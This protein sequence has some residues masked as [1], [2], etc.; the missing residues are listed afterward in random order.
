MKISTHLNIDMVAL[1]H[2]DQVTVLMEFTAPENQASSQRPGRTLMLLLD[3]SGSMAGENLEGAKEAIGRLVR[4]LSRQDCFGL[5]IFDDQAEVVIPPMLIRDHNMEELQRAVASIRAGGMTD[6]SAGYVLALRETKRS[7]KATGHTGATVLLVSDGHANGGITD[8][9]KLKEVA[10]KALKT[11]ITTSTLGLGLGYDESL[12]QEITTGGNGTH[13][14]APDIDAAVHEIQETVADLL[15]VSVLAAT[16]RITP[17]DNHV[18]GI[19]I[20]QDVPVWREP[21]ALV[22]NIG[23]MYAGEERK[24][25]ITLDVPA[26]ADLGTTT[27]ADLDFNFTQVSDLT[28]HHVNLPVTVNVV[29]GDQA[30][31]RVPNPLVEVEELIADTDDA[32]K[33]MIDSLHQDDIGSARSTLASVMKNVNDKRKD[34]KNHG[35][36]SLTLRLDEAALELLKLNESLQ[37]ESREFSSKLMMDSMI[38]GSTGRKKKK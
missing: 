17:K 7:L 9:D 8:P 38:I 26:V 5:I 15:D 21:G 16:L 30:R 20:R 28:D 36:T 4:R 33:S 10:A 18:D 31:N 2:K 27:I 23:D 24:L 6:L 32:K 11:G 29:P 12:L 3:R 25:L 1:D 14:F 37:H 22:V 13:R 35:D 34:L 19:R